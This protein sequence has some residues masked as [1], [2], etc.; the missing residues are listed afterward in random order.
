MRKVRKEPLYGE[1]ADKNGIKMAKE[2]DSLDLRVD[3][4]GEPLRK[5]RALKENL[6]FKTNSAVMIHL[7]NIAKVEK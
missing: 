1:K 7:I 3:L 6:G 2:K 5:F 4:T